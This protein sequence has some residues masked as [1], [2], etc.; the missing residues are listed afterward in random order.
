MSPPA[1]VEPPAPVYGRAAWPRDARIAP[2]RLD[3]VPDAGIAEIERFVA[4][5]GS[6]LL[7]PEPGDA[8]AARLAGVTVAGALP[9][10]EWVVT[11][12]HVP[13]AAR[14]DA[15]AAVVSPLRLMEPSADD[16]EVAA[17]ISV[18][19]RGHPA[20][21]VHTS[22]AGRVVASAIADLDRL[23]LDPVLGRLVARLLRTD[24]PAE[25]REVGVG[26]VGYGPYGGMGYAHGLACAETDG[27]RLV[28]AADTVPERLAA[29]VLD[30]PQVRR[31][32]DVA[33]IAGDEDVELAVVATPPS[34]HAELALALLR[35]GR[36]VVLEKP[37]CLTVAEADHVMAEAERYGRA[38]T[39][40]QSRRWDRDFLAL[41]EAVASGAI[42]DVFAIET[43]VGGFAH[44]CR[45]WHSDEAISG[46]AVYDWGSHHVDWILR[47][48]GGPPTRVTAVA[49]K[50]AWLDVTNADQVTVWMRWA[51]GREAT[52]RQ[53]DLAAIR[54]PKFYVQGTRGTIEGHHRPL[55]TETIE[56]GRGYVDHEA[57]HAEAPVA[58]RLV[59]Y[60]G[61]GRLVEMTVPPAPAPSGWPFHRSLADHLLLGEPLAVPPAE[62]RG[63][64]AVLEAATRSIAAGG[65]PVEVD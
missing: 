42:G 34:S 4:G 2:G 43:F 10:A 51:D 61:P 60:D 65:L 17:T 62:S 5:G 36:H 22:G 19:L 31:Y 41:R 52:F 20:L 21:T 14:L 3:A 1:V 8:V 55:M 54:R 27:L 16:A 18:A 59:R 12:G 37:M 56:R 29:A 33:G 15:E 48:Y 57:H 45:L 28:A 46:G 40:Y 50:R 39:V 32:A 44:P 47:L 26:I 25:T 9:E 23:V 7:A 30:F 38:I 49:H 58:L 24:L 11:L 35:A 13:A 6:L 53:S 64:V 63:V